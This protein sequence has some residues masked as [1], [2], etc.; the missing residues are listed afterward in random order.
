MSKNNT[1]RED[2]IETTCHLLELQ[3]YHATGVNQILAESEAP[4][5]SLYYY[6]PDG[7]EDLAAQAIAH[8]GQR[9]ESRIRLSLAET[10]DPATAVEQFILYIAQQVAQAEYNSGGPITTVALEVASTNAN[11][12]AICRDTFLQWQAVFEEKLTA[13]G[14][15]PAMAESVAVLII[16]AIEGATI[17]ARSQRSVRP[18]E[19]VAT[20]LG[21]LIR[22]K[23][24]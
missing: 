15:D 23:Q 2:I 17:L 19:Q 8:V 9:I 18:L 6:F 1:R 20:Q 13:S 11:L 22:Q 3:G 10:E 14:F 12:N 24:P 16:S 21:Q 7:K 4:K 5:G